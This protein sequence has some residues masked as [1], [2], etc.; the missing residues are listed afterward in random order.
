[1]SKLLSKE[2]LPL[3]AACFRANK[4]AVSALLAAG[5]NVNEPDYYGSPLESAL[6]SVCR[7]GKNHALSRHR[8]TV[9]I[10]K[11]LRDAQAIEPD[12]DRH[13]GV[14]CNGPLCVQAD[15]VDR[16][17]Y[18]ERPPAKHWISGLRYVCT[19]CD[20]PEINLC[21]SCKQKLDVDG[22]PHISN[23]DAVSGMSKSD[24]NSV[25]EL[26]ANHKMTEIQTNDVI[27]KED[28]F[29]SC[30]ECE[31]ESSGY[32]SYIS[33]DSGCSNSELESLSIS[34]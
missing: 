18:Y 27:V 22:T 6:H 24:E 8:K 25:K 32:S 21:S 28:D 16:E 29:S 14:V 15:S 1:M 19:K 10:L 12:S 7:L 5:A 9:E 17:R 11:L 26:H 2:E 33:V 23:H 34:S 13:I 31:R 20:A 30:P 3:P 4:G